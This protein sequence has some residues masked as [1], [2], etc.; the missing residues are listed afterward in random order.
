MHT[1]T[2]GTLARTIG[3]ESF[4]PLAE[5]CIGLG[6]VSGVDCESYEDCVH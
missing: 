6:M 2:L 4:R 1:D 3:E 5:D